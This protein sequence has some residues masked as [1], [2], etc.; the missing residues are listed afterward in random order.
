MLCEL[1]NMQSYFEKTDLELDK[2]GS[3]IVPR[4]DITRELISEYQKFAWTRLSVPMEPGC[5]RMIVI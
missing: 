5:L 4:W 2:L 1:R 3:Q